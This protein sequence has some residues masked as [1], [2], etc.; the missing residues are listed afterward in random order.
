MLVLLPSQY[1]DPCHRISP[2]FVLH[3]SNPHPVTKEDEC[4]IQTGLVSHPENRYL[5]VTTAYLNH[6]K[7]CAQDFFRYFPYPYAPQRDPA[8]PS[9]LLRVLISI[10]VIRILFDQTNYVFLGPKHCVGLWM[11]A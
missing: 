6:R 10:F 11:V 5:A 8:Q 3:L 7:L 1:G 4:G 9:V 2:Q